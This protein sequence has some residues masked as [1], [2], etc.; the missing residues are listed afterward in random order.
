MR[1]N[2]SRQSGVSLL[3]LLIGIVIL[4]ILLL[5][6]SLF[7]LAQPRQLDSVFQFRAVSLVEAFSEQVLAVKYDAANNSSLQLR[8]GIDDAPQCDNKTK[9]SKSN[10]IYDLASVDDFN[11]WCNDGGAVGPIKGDALAKQLDLSD[12]H[13]YQRLELSSCVKVK[14]KQESHHKTV[15]ITVNIDKAGSLLFT[16]QRYN[17]R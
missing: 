8:C 9:L 11:I 16:L 14:D 17:I 13:L 3:E 15:T 6:V 2:G 12:A 7:Y 4:G 5:G 10:H 1:L